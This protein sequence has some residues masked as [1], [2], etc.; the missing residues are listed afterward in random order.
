MNEALLAAQ[1]LRAMRS[2][3]PAK[4]AELIVREAQAE[5]LAPAER[6]PGRRTGSCASGPTPAKRQFAAFLANF[7]ALL[8]RQLGEVDGLQAYAQTAAQTRLGTRAQEAGVS[9]LAGPAVP[10]GIPACFPT[11]APTSSSS[12][13]SR[14]EG[15]GPLPADAWRPARTARRSCSTRA[16]P[17]PTGARASTTS[18]PARSRIWSA[19]STR[20]RGRS[21]TRIAGWDTHGLPVEIE[22]EKELELSGKK[23]IE[24]FGV[25]R[26][27]RAVPRERLQVPGRLGERSPTGSAT[28]STTSIPYITCSNEYI[29]IVWWLLQRLHERGLLY[30]GHRVLPYCPRCGTVLS[31]HELAL[32]Y[33]EVTRPTRST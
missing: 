9:A 23:D 31:S 32:G 27:Q 19:A 10:D 21:V 16:R 15:R 28:G 6:G 22:V 24:A 1:Q 25:A 33:E 4:E 29:E 14:L 2:S 5:A 30:R 20:C 11:S 17:P 12:S 8:E 3:R 18:S 13:C 26:V 7:R